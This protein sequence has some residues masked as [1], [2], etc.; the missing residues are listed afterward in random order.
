MRR[1]EIDKIKYTDGELAISC[2]EWQVDA[3]G[4]AGEGVFVDALDGGALAGDFLDDYGFAKGTS[5]DGAAQAMWSTDK[6]GMAEVI[7]KEAIQARLVGRL[8]TEEN[9]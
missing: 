5:A 1:P 6:I 8:Y 9:I 7:F 2:K 3:A 4:K